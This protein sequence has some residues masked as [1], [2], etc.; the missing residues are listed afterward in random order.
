MA[1]GRLCSKVL[2]FSFQFYQDERFCDIVLCVEGCRFTAHRI[3]LAASSLYFERMFSNGMAEAQAQEVL[4]F[5]CFYQM[6]CRQITYIFVNNVIFS[7]F[8]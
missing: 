7:L 6:A 3:V 8:S 2:S 1:M 4:R 5:Y